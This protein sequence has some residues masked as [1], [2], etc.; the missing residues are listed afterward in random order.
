MGRGTNGSRRSATP[1]AESSPAQPRRTRNPAARTPARDTPRNAGIP[2]EPEPSA[3]DRLDAVDEP[4]DPRLGPY[5][6][7]YD[8]R[9]GY[10]PERT[11]VRP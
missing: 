8:V 9:R 11:V 6:L 3:S 4:G 1:A 10:G 2:V 5:E 7:R